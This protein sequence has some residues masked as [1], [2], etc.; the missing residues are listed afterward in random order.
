LKGF[1]KK[2]HPDKQGWI[3]FCLERKDQTKFGNLEIWKFEGSVNRQPP[4]A[5][6]QLPTT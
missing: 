6:C 3:F 2:I 5:N 4:T 1:H